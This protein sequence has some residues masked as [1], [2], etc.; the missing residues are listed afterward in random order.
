MSRFYLLLSYDVSYHAS[1]VRFLNVSMCN[2]SVY[3]LLNRCLTTTLSIDA[4]YASTFE[5]TSLYADC[6]SK[7]NSL[8]QLS[9]HKSGTSFTKNALNNI[10][11]YFLLAL[12]QQ[13]HNVQNI[14]L[15]SMR[16]ITSLSKRSSILKLQSLDYVSAFHLYL[17]YFT[18]SPYLKLTGV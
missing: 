15:F 12:I 3:G 18:Y 4:F 11:S 1:C 10:L 7:Y 14:G 17:R 2:Q 6:T 9:K 13:F 16:L 8:L 5:H